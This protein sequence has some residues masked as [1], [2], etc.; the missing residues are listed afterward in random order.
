[1]L[2]L[3][4]FIQGMSYGAELPGAIT[5]SSEFNN[6]RQQGV[7][8][9]IV[10]SS[11]AVGSIVANLFMTFFASYFTK[12]EILDFAWRIPFLLG[13]LMG[14]SIFIIRKFLPETAEF[15][16]ADDKAVA[17]MPLLKEVFANYR[18]VVFTGV[19]ASLIGAAGVMVKLYVPSWLI[20]TEAYPADI[21]YR[22]LMFALTVSMVFSNL[23]GA[24]L[25]RFT[26]QSLLIA[27]ATAIILLPYPAMKLIASQDNLNLFIG[28]CLFQFIVCSSQVSCLTWLG[29][30]FPTK[31]RFSGI[32][33]CYN[34]AYCIGSVLP[35]I[36]ALSV[37]DVDQTT[38]TVTMCL[39]AVGAFNLL[40][41]T[42][43]NLVKR[44]HEFKQQQLT[45]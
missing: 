1:G 26:A 10:I 32:A 29:Q 18:A 40:V 22:Q 15:E 17:I 5:I 43:M 24:L 28:F 38:M 3:C 27:C 8:S 2:V 13:G 44:N 23:V 42:R 41:T 36:F 25:K 6:E 4:R 9:G 39:A 12:Q 14:F 16:Q 34:F 45:S 11:I 31:M 30:I 7:G 33:I 37:N 35:I 20:Q 19:V 21:V